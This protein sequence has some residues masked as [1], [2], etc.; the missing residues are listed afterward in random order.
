MSERRSDDEYALVADLYDHVVPYRERLDVE[1]F[2]DAAVEA[3]GPSLEIGCGTGR[4]LIPTAR[5]GVD[6]VGLDLSPHMLS[7][8]RERLR[9]ETEPVQSRVTLVQADM[10]RFDLARRFALITLPF[11]PFQHL[12]TVGE[13]M[14]CLESIRRHLADDGRLIL[15]LFNPSLDALAGPDDDEERSEEPE[16]SMPD[17]R[18]VVRRHKVVARDRFTQVNRIELIYY[19]M[20]PDGRQE[21][22]VHGFPMRYLFRFEV[23]H[24]LARCG[25]EVERL[26]AGFDKSA[27]GSTYPGEL[28]FVARR[29]PPQRGQPFDS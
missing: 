16:F 1:F 15:D 26:Y 10:R 4:V 25:F 19:V 24:L 23:E 20:H 28:I 5:A 27:Y 17:G 12:I 14:S 2:V 13:Q 29:A 7:V 3:G 11:R 6:I 22:L 8:C 18:R 21:R 9:R